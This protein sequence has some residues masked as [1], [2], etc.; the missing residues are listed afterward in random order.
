MITDALDWR[1]VFFV[2]VPVG[3][4][5][6]VVAVTRM[7]ESRDPQATRTDVWGLLTFSGSLFLIVFG[8]LR[9]NDEGWTSA[10]ILGSLIGGA[11]LLLV[12]VAVEHRQARPM[13][14]L[15]LFRSGP[16][17]GVSLATIAIGAGMFALFPYLS[18]YLQDILG[19]S[20]LGA[21][22]RFLPLTSSSS[23]CRC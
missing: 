15:G 23:S 18:I 13:L 10:L 17:D 22:L 19:Y 21:G 1:W 14:D 16:F 5:A 20:P 3:V 8:V 2:N 6:L 12:F 4:F 11:V 7:R 9:G